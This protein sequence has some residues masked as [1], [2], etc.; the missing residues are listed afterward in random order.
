[1]AFAQ[2]TINSE[3]KMII[4]ILIPPLPDIANLNTN[5]FILSKVYTDK[6]GTE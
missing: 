4:V 6:G 2:F 1:M 5:Y 3:D